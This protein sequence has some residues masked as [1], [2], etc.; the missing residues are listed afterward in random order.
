MNCNITQIQLGF[1]IMYMDRQC[2]SISTGIYRKLELLLYLA[3]G[4]LGNDQMTQDLV[5]L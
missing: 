4:V 2:A 1:I 3:Y 5:A